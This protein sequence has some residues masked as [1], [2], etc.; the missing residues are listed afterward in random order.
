MGGIKIPN[1]ISVGCTPILYDDWQLTCERMLIGPKRRKRISAREAEI[2]TVL[3]AHATELVY[4]DAFSH[5]GENGGY[6]TKDALLEAVRRLRRNMDYVGLPDRILVKRLSGF[7]LLKSTTIGI[8]WQKNI[9][10]IRE[11]RQHG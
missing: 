4:P 7:V 1:Y 5:I 6:K 3:H 9:L 10:A 11:T 2:L 8:A